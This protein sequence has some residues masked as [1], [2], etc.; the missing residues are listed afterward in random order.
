MYDMRPFQP[1]YAPNAG[2]GAGS[3]IASV[4]ISA[5]TTAASAAL[6]G[7]VQTNDFNQIQIANTTTGWAYINFARSTAEIAAA[8]VAAGYPVAPGGV[9]V[10][11][12]TSEVA[13]TSVI[14][15]TSSGSVI[16]TRGTGA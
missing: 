5:S 11:T 10:V 16:F 15:G 12:V 3:L 7:N 2:G 6:P 14:L 13:A 9:V 1:L 8:T 4:T